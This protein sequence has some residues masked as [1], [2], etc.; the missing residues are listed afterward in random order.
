M[1]KSRRVPFSL[2][3]NIPLTTPRINFRIS[4]CHHRFSIDLNLIIIFS[5]KNGNSKKIPLDHTDPLT[6][7][8]LPQPYPEF[9]SH[10]PIIELLW[11]RFFFTLSCTVVINLI[12]DYPSPL[13]VPNSRMV[14]LTAVLG[15]LYTILR[16]IS[17]DGDQSL[18]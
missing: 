6:F 9:V 7:R 2:F 17:L 1:Y 14:L 11:W 10:V 15:N 13:N 4:E 3:V 16:S 18:S 12:N 8:S 5:A